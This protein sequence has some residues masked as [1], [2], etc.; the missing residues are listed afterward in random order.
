MLAVGQMSSVSGVSPARVQRRVA[1]KRVSM[2]PRRQQAK[3][4]EPTIVACNA[5]CLAVGRFVALPFFKGSLAKA[6]PPKQDG[7]THF[8]AGDKRAAEA[9]FVTS[10]ND[11]AGFTI[12]DTLVWGSIGHALGYASLASQSFVDT[13]AK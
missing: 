3:A 4:F 7:K 11:P 5:A 10:T 12:V 6:G 1:S 13:L 9:S 2:A 8:D